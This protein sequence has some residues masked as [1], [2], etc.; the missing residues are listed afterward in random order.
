MS[1]PQQNTVKHAKIIKVWSIQS[2]WKVWDFADKNFKAMSVKGQMGMKYT[3]AVSAAGEG[4][5]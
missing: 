5:R 4:G 3:F 1:N 2:E